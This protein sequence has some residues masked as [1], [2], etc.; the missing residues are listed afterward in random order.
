MH[1]LCLWSLCVAVEVLPQDRTSVVVVVV[2]ADI[3]TD[4]ATEERMID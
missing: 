3:S 1:C 2:T 4:T